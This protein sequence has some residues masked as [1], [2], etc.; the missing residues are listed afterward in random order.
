[1]ANFFLQL[2]KNAD[3]FPASLALASRTGQLSYKSLVRSME[4]VTANAV[5]AGIGPGQ[6][7]LVDCSNS[8]ARLPLIFGLMR[9]GATVGIGSAADTFIEH[10]VG[11]DAVVTDKPHPK[12]AWRVIRLSAQWFNAP[13]KG[14]PAPANRDYSLM[15]SSSGSTGKMKLVRFSRENIEYRIKVKLD[16]LYYRDCPRYLSTS[17]NASLTTFVDFMITLTKGGLIILQSDRRSSSI[18]DTISL[19]RPTY[20]SMA[21]S[22]LVGILKLLRDRPRRFEMIDYLRLAGSYCSVE[23]REKAA[24]ILAKNIVTSYGATEI[25]RVA[26]GQLADIRHTEGS[27]GRIIDGVV[28]ETVDDG[29]NPLPA[30]SEGEIRIRPP[31]AAVASYV[32]GQDSQTPLRDGWFYPGDLGRVGPDRSLIVTGRKSLVMNLGGVKLSPEVAESII[33]KME[34]VED[35]GVL[36]I[37]DSDGLDVACAAVVKKKSVDLEEINDHLFKEKCSAPISKLKFVSAVPRTA[38]G[39]IDRMGLRELVG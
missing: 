29:G 33:Q 8:D 17:G 13:T 4:A 30:G 12:V 11:V 9:T 6:T 21:P 16:D 24:E 36:A 5:A 22:T 3:R 37:K 27:V 31:K 34:A 23:T 35:V 39:K 38:N 19:L 10:N 28:V 14:K 26:W 32:T 1:V 18:L 20:V 25:S 7:I 2:K 15:F